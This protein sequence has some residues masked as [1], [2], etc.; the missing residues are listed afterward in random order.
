MKTITISQKLLEDLKDAIKMGILY[1]PDSY[2]YKYCWEE[3]TDEE[4]EK[5]KEVKDSMNKIL[6]KCKKMEI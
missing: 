2:H 1:L 6:E 3:C 5:V 4:Q